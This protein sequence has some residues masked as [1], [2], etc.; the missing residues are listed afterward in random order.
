MQNTKEL[1]HETVKKDYKIL[2]FKPC[3]SD[4]VNFSNK[5]FQKDYVV[6]NKSDDRRL[7]EIFNENFIN[8]TKTL[9]NLTVDI[10]AGIMKG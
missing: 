2:F 10:P 9:V 4:K 8:I 5:K 1:L 6:S 3:F 7:S